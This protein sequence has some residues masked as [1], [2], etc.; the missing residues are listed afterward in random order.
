MGVLLIK[1]PVTGREF[2]TGLQISANDAPTLP[3]ALSQAPSRAWR[4]TGQ[5]L[6]AGR[7]AH[8]RPSSSK[9][10]RSTRIMRLLSRWRAMRDIAASCRSLSFRAQRP[11]RRLVGPFIRAL[12]TVIERDLVP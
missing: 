2:S 11:R 6:A 7:S 3:D 8:K 1:C 10:W 4:R 5:A 12:E 9:T